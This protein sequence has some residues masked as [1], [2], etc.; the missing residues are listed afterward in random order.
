[1]IHV[2]AIVTAKPGQRESLLEAFR[3]IIPLVRDEA[4][5]IEYNAT[6]D[7][8]DASPAFGPDTFVVIEKW[9]NPATLKA[10]GA[11]SHMVEYGARTRDLVASVQVHVLDPA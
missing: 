8:A 2:V 6:V 5:C 4:G 1:M 10:H 9:E 11:S 7:V 3:L